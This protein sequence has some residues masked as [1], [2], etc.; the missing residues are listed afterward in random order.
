[1]H[2]RL[3]RLPAKFSSKRPVCYWHR[4]EPKWCKF[5]QKREGDRREERWVNFPQKGRCV[6]DTDLKERRAHTNDSSAPLDKNQKWNFKNSCW[7]VLFCLRSVKKLLHWFL[8][9]REEAK[10]L[11]QQNKKLTSSIIWK[12][13]VK[14]R[15][16][17]DLKTNTTTFASAKVFHSFSNKAIIFV[18]K[19]ASRLFCHPKGESFKTCWEQAEAA[20]KRLSASR[21]L[22]PGYVFSWLPA[23]DFSLLRDGFSE[24]FVFC[25]LLW[26]LL[27]FSHGGLQVVQGVQGRFFRWR[28]SSVQVPAGDFT[29]RQSWISPHWSWDDLHLDDDGWERGRRVRCLEHHRNWFHSRAQPASPLAGADSTA[30][31]VLCVSRQQSQQLST[32]GGFV[33]G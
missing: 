3:H 25:P 28:Q 5:P 19:S 29:W 31:D 21:S 23:F 11:K 32:L 1:M 14:G 16:R 30:L 20:Q 13:P 10:H 8:W 22:D 17:Q 33:S 7:A 12:L 4:L 2:Y 15:T 6:I 24:G 27:Q 26:W 18:P 9:K